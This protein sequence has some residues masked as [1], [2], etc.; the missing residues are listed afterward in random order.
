M[1]QSHRRQNAGNTAAGSSLHSTASPSSAPASPR[2]AGVAASMASAM[3]P[4]L[5][6]STWPLPA[7]SQIGSG[8]QA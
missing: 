3:K 6:A 4:M 2:R 5:A 8:H 1:R 7:N